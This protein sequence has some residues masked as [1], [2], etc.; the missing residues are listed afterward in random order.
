MS[1]GRFK[2]RAKQSDMTLNIKSLSL[3]LIFH[4]GFHRM[5]TESS[6]DIMG[7][8]ASG[9]ESCI[10]STKTQDSGYEESDRAM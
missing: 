4:Q 6:S 8:G 7:F 3:Q 5:N 10:L 2:E 1:Q 9:V